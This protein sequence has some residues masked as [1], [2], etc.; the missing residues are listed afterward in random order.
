MGHG[1]PI[2]SSRK[3]KRPYCPFKNF[4]VFLNG[5]V[6]EV[7]LAEREYL[8]SRVDELEFSMDIANWQ[9][10]Q[11]QARVK[12]LGDDKANLEN[13]LSEALQAPFNKYKKKEAT[14]N[15]KKRGVPLHFFI[16]TLF[17]Q[18]PPLS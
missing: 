16:Y 18:F 15:S 14:E 6:P 3:A 5:E 17:H 1:K 4:C 2:Y 11:L 9:A 10:M 7:I 12:E 13:E 8:R